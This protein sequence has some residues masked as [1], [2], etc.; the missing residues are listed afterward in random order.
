MIKSRAAV[1]W[2]ANQ[3]LQIEEIDV[4]PPQPGEI[5]VRIIATGENK[6]T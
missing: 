3:P 4:M 6:I 5:L 2:E 1:A